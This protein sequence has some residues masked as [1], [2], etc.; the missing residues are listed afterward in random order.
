MV[1]PHRRRRYGPLEKL[2]A[3]ALDTVAKRRS[4][5]ASI[6]M[7]SGTLLAGR[8]RLR[9][10]LG[11]GGMAVVWAADDEVLGRAV[12]IKQLHAPTDDGS[13]RFSREARIGAKLRHP[14]LVTVF[15]V[16]TDGPN[17]LLVMELVDGPSL[18]AVLEDGPLP[19][20]DV[21]RILEPVAAALD[22]VHEAGVVHRDVKPAN[23][24]V[25]HDGQTRLAD[26]GIA[27][28]AASTRITGAGT[29]LGTPA[30]I[31]PEQLEGQDAT[32]ASDVYALAA[33]AFAAL[34]GR[35]A[36][37]GRDALAILLAVRTTP[38]PRLREY[39]PGAPQGAD[40]LLARG[41]AR[42]PGERPAS[43]RELIHGLAAALA[44]SIEAPRLIEPAPQPAAGSRPPRRRPSRGPLVV[45]MLALALVAGT[46][47]AIL[48]SG[49]DDSPSKQVAAATRTPAPS[50]TRT[51]TPT[52]TATPT[53]TRTPAPS[54]RPTGP[55][56][57]VRAFYERAAAGDFAG[58]YE[59]AGPQ[60][61]AALG[62][63]QAGL[64]RN[65][66]SLRSIEFREVEV[67]SQDASGATVRI[68][69]VARHTNRTD[70]CAGTL[71]ALRT[72][73]GW[74]VDPAGV[75]C[76]RISG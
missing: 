54:G 27:T 39:W 35:P 14:G 1:F 8:Y 49:N 56:A 5:L 63:S 6:A 62:D 13:R 26:L 30:Y 47:A 20:A 32:P 61:R 15:D 19:A 38:A 25:G 76:R 75:Q 48:A 28:A 9:R 60:M 41:L 44:P 72:P 36:R 74:R 58:A 18:A 11:T 43:A 7:D 22:H 50:P 34:S 59:L 66:G 45:G 40:D 24:L 42:D 12:A 2:T 21:L 10:K 3:A 73:D 67:V 53:P 16:V 55:A 31:A 65:L 70:A 29:I 64:E 68:S 37:S 17:V 33:V 23:I 52:A 69:T 71:R 46:L 51:P 4:T 57:A